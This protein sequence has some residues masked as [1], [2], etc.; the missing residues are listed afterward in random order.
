MMHGSFVRYAVAPVDMAD[1]TEDDAVV[2]VLSKASIP[3]NELFEPKPDEQLV[4]LSSA[5]SSSCQGAR[6]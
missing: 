2:G 5:P 4:L 6:R 1:K 3:N